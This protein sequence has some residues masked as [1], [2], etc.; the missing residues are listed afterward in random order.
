MWRRRILYRRRATVFV[1]G[2]RC[3]NLGE[4]IRLD[5]IAVVTGG[6]LVE[7]PPGAPISLKGNDS[8]ANPLSLAFDGNDATYWV[9]TGTVA[10]FC[11]ANYL[12]TNAVAA[13]TLTS[14]NNSDAL[15][16][17]PQTW[18][19]E[20]IQQRHGVATVQHGQRIF[21]ES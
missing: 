9:N 14:A 3:G 19:L 18:T 4:S 21:F 6:N 10:I 12:P 16:T 17:D 1:W 20:G 7:L 13:Y 15:S 11:A 5:N 2:A 8:P